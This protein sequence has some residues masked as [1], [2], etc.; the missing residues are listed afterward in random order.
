MGTARAFL[1]EITGTSPVMTDETHCAIR[2][3]FRD[4][5]QRRTRNPEVGTVRV[6]GF[7]VRASRAPE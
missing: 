4:G 6:S 2:S 1:S 7:R 5:A 3:S